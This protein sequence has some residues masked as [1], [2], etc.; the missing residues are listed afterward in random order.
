[1][2]LIPT[3][4]GMSIPIFLGNGGTVPMWLLMAMIGVGLC[5]VALAVILVMSLSGYDKPMTA[6]EN[7]TERLERRLG[8]IGLFLALL[9]PLLGAGAVGAAIGWHIE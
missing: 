6:F 8:I 3:G 1:M 9:V 4:R 7:Y 5:A 2:I